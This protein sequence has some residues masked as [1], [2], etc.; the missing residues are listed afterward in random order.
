MNQQQEILSAFK[1]GGGIDALTAWLLVISSEVEPGMTGPD[2]EEPCID[3]RLRYFAG[4]C[5]VYSGDS[6]Y[7][8]DHRGHWG[9]S[10][11]PAGL[12]REEAVI[13]ARDLLTQV[14]ESDAMCADED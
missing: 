10:S 4:T 13:I 6:Q 8:T 12:T 7:D 9:A 5:G 3:V 2:R 1:D 14:L 11:V